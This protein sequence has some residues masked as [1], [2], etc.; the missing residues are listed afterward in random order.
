MKTRKRQLDTENLSCVNYYQEVRTGKRTLLVEINDAATQT[1]VDKHMSANEDD[2]PHSFA[3]ENGYVQ[4]TFKIANSD[5]LE[6]NDALISVKRGEKSHTSTWHIFT[7]LNKAP[8]FPVSCLDSS[9]HVV[10]LGNDVVDFIAEDKP[11][12]DK[13]RVFYRILVKHNKDAE[14]NTEKESL[15]E[16]IL[17]A[18]DLSTKEILIAYN[19]KKSW[20][21]IEIGTQIADICDIIKA[22]KK[23]KYIIVDC[24]LDEIKLNQ[25]ICFVDK[26]NKESLHTMVNIADTSYSGKLF[27]SRNAGSTSG[28]SPS[29]TDSKW[30]F[31]WFDRIEGMREKFYY[32]NVDRFPAVKI[33][34]K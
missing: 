14:I 25:A 11:A 30:P 22:L 15:R 3:R 32:T 26:N 12:R 34:K 2:A 5:N 19:N 13:K 8:K 33:Y 27:M 9:E 23:Q 16:V 18:D 29:Y 20:F 1:K 28:L 6:F 17:A 21:E 7:K 4:F 24:S 10:A 31:L